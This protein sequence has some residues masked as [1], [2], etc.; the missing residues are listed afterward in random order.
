M[1]KE[2]Q[3]NMVALMEGEERSVYTIPVI[4]HVVYNTP[5]ENL[6]EAEIN[7]LL[8]GVNEDFSASNPD[9]GETRG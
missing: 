7:D 4:F 8:D 3:N 9:V 2:Y 1:E 5:A 6:S